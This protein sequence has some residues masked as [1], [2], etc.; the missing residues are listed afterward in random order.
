MQEYLTL[1]P[2]SMMGILPEVV[3]SAIAKFLYLQIIHFSRQ[4]EI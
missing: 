1:E 4:L 3:I 2:V